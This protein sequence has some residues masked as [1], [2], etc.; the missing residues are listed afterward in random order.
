MYVSGIW[1]KTHLPLFQSLGRQLSVNSLQAFLHFCSFSNF[2]RTVG[3]G[4]GLVIN[5]KKLLKNV[6]DLGVLR[7]GKNDTKKVRITAAAF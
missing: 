3:T 1:W 2:R 5:L 4:K 6:F 7:S